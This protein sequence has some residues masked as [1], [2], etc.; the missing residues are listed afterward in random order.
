[1]SGFNVRD[2]ARRASGV[3]GEFA[4]EDYPKRCAICSARMDSDTE[5]ICSACEEPNKCDAG[6]ACDDDT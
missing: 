1:M 2:D 6:Y 4:N 5:I 3:Y